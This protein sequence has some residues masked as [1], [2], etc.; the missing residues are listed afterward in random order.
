ML[1][2][3][4]IDADRKIS[5]PGIITKAFKFLIRKTMWIIIHRV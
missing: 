5:K 4:L 2:I 3:R 1:S